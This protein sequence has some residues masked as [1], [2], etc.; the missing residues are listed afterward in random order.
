MCPQLQVSV[1][2]HSGAQ[3]ASEIA[4]P[5]LDSSVARALQPFLHGAMILLHSF[6][7]PPYNLTRLALAAAFDPNKD[8]D[9]SGQGPRKITSFFAQPRNAPSTAASTTDSLAA[10]A[11][12]ASTTVSIAAPAPAAS[13]A[14]SAPT[15]SATTFTQGDTITC[16][17]AELQ[18]RSA[19]ELTTAA[20]AASE[21][22][23][24]CGEMI[25]V[26]PPNGRLAAA[27]AAGE[28]AEPW[29]GSDE[30]CLV[31]NAGISGLAEDEPS[32]PSEPSAPPVSKPQAKTAQSVHAQEL[33]VSVLNPAKEDEDHQQL[34]VPAKAFLHQGT[35]H[36]ESKLAADVSAGDQPMH[37]LLP[38]PDMACPSSSKRES[39]T[40]LEAPAARLPLGPSEPGRSA[41][42]LSHDPRSPPLH[43]NAEKQSKWQSRADHTAAAA[44]ETEPGPLAHSLAHD[45]QM[46]GQSAGREASGLS[47]AQEPTRCSVSAELLKLQ[48]LFAERAGQFRPG[49]AAAS[50]TKSTTAGG[51]E[52]RDAALAA[53]LQQEE[54]LRGNARPAS[55]AQV[56]I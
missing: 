20:A 56:L 42:V 15:P 8:T 50:G 9:L 3:P 11:I 25:D 47:A 22:P 49:S 44:A 29:D 39:G 13:P 26:A 46:I 54:C 55:F 12:A 21:P 17:E 4:E 10:P 32:L 6:I 23:P 38:P 41:P 52:A 27:A 37:P 40:V 30:S 5:R 31:N 48:S 53:R 2:L 34:H 36:D 18:V 45:S 7:K 51:Q 33:A 28:P 43:S 1:C 35:I 19:L 14:A 16:D 24:P